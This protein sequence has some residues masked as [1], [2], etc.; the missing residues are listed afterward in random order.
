MSEKQRTRGLG[1]GLSALLSEPEAEREELPKESREI[2]EGARQ[3]PIELIR[4][5]PAQ[6]RRTFDAEDLADLSASIKERGVLQ[7]LLLRP[8]EDEEFEIVAGERRWRAAQKAGLHEVPAVIR[9]LT[10][11]ETL[12]I[13][14]IENVQRADLN[15]LE[16][17][18]AYDRLMKDFSRTQAEV[19]DVVGKSRAH[20][21]NMLR[22]LKLPAPVRKLLSDGALSAGHA[23][24]LANADNPEA[25]ARRVVKEGLSVRAVEDLARKPETAKKKKPATKSK[26]ADT[27]ALE[28]D[29][30]SALGLSVDIRHK[31]EAG[32]LRLS[33]KSLEQ[34]DDLC[35]RL[36]A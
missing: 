26:D 28:A 8:T 25:L 17:A 21:A 30:A 36:T 27:A 34:L 5:N 29:I 33:Y 6:P 3:I 22:L 14:I 32:E 12:E 11:A 19:A 23:R 31:G 7:P 2:L 15:P 13:A 20:V 35:R 18:D 9:R 16:E 1:R 4:P 24:A 10:D